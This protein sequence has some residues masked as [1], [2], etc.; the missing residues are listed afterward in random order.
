MNKNKKKQNEAFAHWVYPS[1]TILS[2]MPSIPIKIPIL[3]YLSETET[4]PPIL[5]LP[6]LHFPILS[7]F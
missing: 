7:G 5:K 1:Q 3:K 4:E 2:Q 6:P